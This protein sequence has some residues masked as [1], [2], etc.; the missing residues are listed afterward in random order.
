MVVSGVE[1]PPM[2]VPVVEAPPLTKVVPASEV[3]TD[4]VRESEDGRTTVLQPWRTS[5]AM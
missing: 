4:A 3:A 1:V 2:E 5:S